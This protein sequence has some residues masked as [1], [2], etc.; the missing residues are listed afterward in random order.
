ML[1]E[2]QDN[3]LNIKNTKKYKHTHIPEDSNK[4]MKSTY[5]SGKY[6]VERLRYSTLGEY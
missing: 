5:V 1:Q 4:D 6:F 3:Y 2:H